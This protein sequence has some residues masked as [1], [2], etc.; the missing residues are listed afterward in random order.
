MLKLAKI[1]RNSTH[2]AVAP[3]VLMEEMIAVC[4]RIS[5]GDFEARVMGIPNAPGKER[6]LAQRM[7]EMIDRTDA[8]VRESKACLGFIAQNRHFRRIAEDGLQGGFLTAARSTNTA[9][10]GIGHT[11]GAFGEL[12]Q[13]L[14]T[15]V[16]TFQDK[17]SFLSGIADSTLEESGSVSNSANDALMDIQ[18]VSAAAEELTQSIQEINR[19]VAHCTEI[20]GVAVAESNATGKTVETLAV[21]SER[22]GDAVQLINAIAMQTNLLALN[23][24]IEAARA[25]EA[26]KGFAVVA[27]EV[28][29]L[30]QETAKATDEIKTQVSE[31]QSATR[32]SVDSISVIGETIQQLDGITSAIAESIGEQGAAT[33]EIARLIEGAAS[34][35]SNITTGIGAVSTRM[36]DVSQS[37][38]ELQEIAGGLSGQVESLSQEL[39]V[40]E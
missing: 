3:D 31:I 8:Y 23:A 36:G 35:V 20:S 6:D 22:I 39:A 13:Y 17:A 29:I 4:E 11:L 28:K 25:G 21:A 10:D 27:A 16:E 34:G 19:Q 32:K 9:A 33:N 14:E 38:S 5:A 18:S 26:G 15:A 30:A 37:S 24:T 2:S 12:V 40:K 1:R 7:N